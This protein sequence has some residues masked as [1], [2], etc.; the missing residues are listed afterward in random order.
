MG[1]FARGIGAGLGALDDTRQVDELF[2]LLE[3]ILISG[4]MRPGLRGKTYRLVWTLTLLAKSIL[5]VINAIS[6][7]FPRT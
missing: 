4:R 2:S 5:L 7:S 1:G 3:F 6:T